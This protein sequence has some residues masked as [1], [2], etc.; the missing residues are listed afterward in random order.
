MKQSKQLNLIHIIILIVLGVLA[1][2][3]SRAAGEKDGL[4]KVY[5][6]DVGQGDSIFIEAPN[7]NQVLV[8]GGPDDKVLS[9][10][11]K[12]VPF[13]DHDI[14]AVVAT[15]PHADHIA[16]LV[17]VLEHYQVGKIIEAKEEYDS[18]TY[19][20][21]EKAI[22]EENAEIIEAL[23]GTVLDLGNVVTVTLLYPLASVA[24]TTTNRPHDDAVVAM[25]KYS[26]FKVLLTGDMEVKTEE[27][28]LMRGVDV[29]A[30]I[31]K[32]GHHGSKTSSGGKFLSAVSPQLAVIQ[33]G[34]RNRYRHP[35]PETI[36]RMTANGIRDHRNDTDGTVEILSDGQNYQVKKY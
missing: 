33:V 2:N 15:H 3:T 11:G 31:L 21:W 24:G 26:D 18:A 6:L 12:I 19:R 30:D 20:A 29:D 4:L 16:G 9:E 1:L 36:S 34:A 32:I 28:L 10:L 5:F 8:D 22:Q 27:E 17:G 35:S 13:Y 23:G 14:D 25:L 7:G